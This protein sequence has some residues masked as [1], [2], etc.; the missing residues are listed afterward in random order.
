MA[1]LEEH[2]IA[3]LI[4]EHLQKLVGVYPNLA[5]HCYNSVQERVSGRNFEMLVSESE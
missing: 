4:P 5:L 3:D 1:S 2:A